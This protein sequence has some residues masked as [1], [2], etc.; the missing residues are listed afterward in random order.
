MH[1]EKFKY[2]VFISYRWVWPEFRWVRKDLVPA[3]KAAGLKVWIDLEHNKIPVSLYS[4]TVKGIANSRRVLCVITP[5]YLKETRKPASWAGVEFTVLQDF[6]DRVVPLILRGTIPDGIRDRLSFNWVHPRKVAREWKDFLT[7]MEA[8]NLEAPAPSVSILYLHFI[9]IWIRRI[10]YALVVTA[11][12]MFVIIWLLQRQPSPLP[13]LT[14]ITVA[15]QAAKPDMTVAPAGTVVGAVDVEVDPSLQV[16]VYVQRKGGDY[17]DLWQCA[18]TSRVTGRKWSLDN[19]SF[20]LPLHPGATQ[21]TIQPLLRTDDQQCLAL[22]D[23]DF[24]QLTKSNNS[25][26]IP[27][28]LSVAPPVATIS[29]VSVDFQGTFTASGTVQNTLENQE[30]LWVWVD[31]R[32]E[33]SGAFSQCFRTT[34]S[35]GVWNVAGR[36]R[37]QFKS[38]I[39]AVEVGLVSKGFEGSSRPD[40][41]HALARETNIETVLTN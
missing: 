9:L 5:A 11:A 3:L 23:S 35:N 25:S 13:R 2:D 31:V 10:S 24:T 12:V 30:D 19:V 26:A 20:R 32:S 38:D 40:N 14:I 18:G 6:K 17:D 41:F 16:F 39:Y 22:H 33:T 27:L 37:S 1:E 4:Q 36:L 8:A 15:G 28:H 21:T 29:G 34:S 7:A